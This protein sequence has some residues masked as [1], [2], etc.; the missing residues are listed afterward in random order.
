MS[1]NR[2]IVIKITVLSVRSDT[3]ARVLGFWYNTWGFRSTVSIA[4]APFH[5]PAAGQRI[6]DRCKYPRRGGISMVGP[7]DCRCCCCCYAV[8]YI[9]SML[10]TGQVYHDVHKTNR[11]QTHKQSN[12]ASSRACRVCHQCVLVHEDCT[13]ISLIYVYFRSGN[14]CFVRLRNFPLIHFFCAVANDKQTISFHSNQPQ[15]PTPPSQCHTGRVALNG[16]ENFLPQRCHAKWSSLLAITHLQ[17]TSFNNTL[18][19]LWS[20]V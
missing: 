3:M 16:G 19:L 10:W 15:Q 8:K 2:A 9:E 4:S 12:S 13:E 14:G 5:V 11:Q 20:S 17:D 18:L 7:S 1:C 6:D